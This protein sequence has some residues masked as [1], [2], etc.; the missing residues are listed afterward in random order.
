M[1]GTEEGLRVISWCIFCWFESKWNKAADKCAS[2]D[3][4]QSLLDHIFV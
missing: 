1:L 2:M 3:P 4:E